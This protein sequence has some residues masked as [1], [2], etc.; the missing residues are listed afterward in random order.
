MKHA[1]LP[2]NNP[3]TNCLSS[4]TAAP[5]SCLVGINTLLDRVPVLSFCGAD[6]NLPKNS[7]LTNTVP[8]SSPLASPGR[9]NNTFD[10]T[11]PEDSLP[12]L[13]VVASTSLCLTFLPRRLDLPCCFAPLFVTSTPN[14]T[15]ARELAGPPNGYHH[16]PRTARPHGYR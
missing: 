10:G 8:A 12:P 14:P 3:A 5:R 1:S 9:I 6:Y 2:H 15:F 4:H 7:V 16:V 11:L 13:I